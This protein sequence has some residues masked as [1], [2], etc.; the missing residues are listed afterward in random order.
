M[1][2]KNFQN[3]Q[4]STMTNLTLETYKQ[5]FDSNSHSSGFDKYEST[6]QLLANLLS[7]PSKLQRYLSHLVEQSLKIKKSKFINN[8]YMDI[9]FNG[10][11]KHVS[12][13]QLLANLL[14]KIGKSSAPS[15]ITR[16]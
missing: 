5:I 15:V 12:V 8:Q 1:K 10:K 9:N 7:N 6:E 14:C 11:Q 4:L 13:N 2:E 16:K 3:K